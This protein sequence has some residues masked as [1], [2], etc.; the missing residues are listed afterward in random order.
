[1]GGRAACFA[2]FVYR[3][4]VYLVNKL[5]DAARWRAPG[6]LE[7]VRRFLNTSEHLARTRE[8]RDHLPSLARDGK[9]WEGRFKSVRRPRDD[10]LEELTALRTGLRCAVDDDLDAEWL[11]EQIGA[12][13]LTVAVDRR[14]STIRYVP[15]SR[16][17]AVSDLL[18]IVLEAIAEGT[19]Q[20]LKACPDCQL[21]FF[22]RTRNASKRW[23]QMS[24]RE[25][26]RA[27]GSIAKVRSWRARK[28]GARQ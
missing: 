4:N 24:A 26:G 9:A 22:D 16:P 28:G 18:A 5:E 2:E 21:V 27:C 15:A 25:G 8:D 6:R 10:E 11:N 7:D 23:C 1:L 12:A 14:G 13:G 17:A 19:W 20:R 3:Q